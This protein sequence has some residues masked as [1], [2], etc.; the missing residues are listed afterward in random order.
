ME[1]EDL[2]RDL[3]DVLNQVDIMMIKPSMDAK[4]NLQQYRKTIRKREDKKLDYERYQN[5][6]DTL[7][8]KKARS[9][10]DN[11]V[12]AKVESEL[13]TATESYKAA[14]DHLRENLPPLLQAIYSLQ[15]HLLAAQ[16]N[17]QNSLL[18][19]YYTS[20]HSYCTEEGFPNPAPPMDEVI[21]LWDDTLRPIQKEFEAIGIVS[22]GKSIRKALENGH[23]QSNGHRRTSQNSSLSRAPSISPARPLAPALSN[24]SRPKITSS[25][26]ASSIFSQPIAE[27]PSETAALS[28]S[29]LPSAYA[30]PGSISF[31]PAG[32]NSDYF[33]RD[34]QTSN[35]YA[36]TTPHSAYSFSPGATSSTTAIASAAAAA[37]AKKKPPPPPPPPRMNSHQ[38]TFVTA[39]Y[40]FGGQ[41]EG[42]L[43]FREGDRIKV[44]KKTGS[45]DDWWQGELRGV[46]GMFPANYCS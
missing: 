11:Q 14:D 44:L 8:K 45:T 7:M 10:R 25:P 26:S 5:R 17:I 23:S 21:R 34:R 32:P 12:L 39:L 33:S 28:P 4:D 27:T 40:D 20:L 15:P 36:S 46:K 29:P 1:S 6:V 30:T 35:S 16:V 42:D 43:V 3:K 31:S 9:D 18:G 37:A 22:S 24:E 38:F 2:K 41:G 13:A 19:H